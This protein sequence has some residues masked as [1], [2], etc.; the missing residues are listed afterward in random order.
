MPPDEQPQYSDRQPTAARYYKSK[1]LSPPS[2]YVQKDG[3]YL[4]YAPSGFVRESLGAIPDGTLAHAEEIGQAEAEELIRVRLAEAERIAKVSQAEAERFDPGWADRNAEPG[5]S[6]AST[7]GRN[8]LRVVGASAAGLAVFYAVWYATEALAGSGSDAFSASALVG[9]AYWKIMLPP[10]LGAF[11]FALLCAAKTPWRYGWRFGWGIVILVPIVALLT[12]DSQALR[13]I[14]ERY[15]TSL[16]SGWGGEAL[17]VV[18]F[19]LPYLA[20]G[21]LGGLTADGAARWARRRR[22][23]SA[24]SR[25]RAWHLAAGVSVLAVVAVV[26]AVVV[27]TTGETDTAIRAEDRWNEATRLVDQGEAAETAGNT[28]EALALYSQAIKTEPGYTGGWSSK[29]FLLIHKGRFEEA[30]E[31]AEGWTINIPANASSWF[32]K[33]YALEGLGRYE[34]AIIAYRRAQ[35]EGAD[36]A[37]FGDNTAKLARERQAGCEEILSNPERAEQED[38]IREVSP[39]VALVGEANQPL[40]GIAS[41]TTD[42]ECISILTAYAADLD[43]CIAQAVAIQPASSVK[44]VHDQLLDALRT[45]RRGATGMCSALETGNQ[46]AYDRALEVLFSGEDK[47]SAYRESVLNWKGESST[48]TT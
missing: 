30:L 29:G 5:S 10:L 1:H 22:L 38:Y 23:G 32:Q 17:S 18:A 11:V 42:A 40:G 6:L 47:F 34:D 26:A 24:N 37:Q 7:M 8:A 45:Y 16:S 19:V 13:L 28:E 14:S 35:T 36:G 4:T 21:S 48:S 43:E 20:L 3:L 44:A 46:V 2:I 25:L 41:E 15:N 33:G 39:L 31:N 9:A 27:H 12:H